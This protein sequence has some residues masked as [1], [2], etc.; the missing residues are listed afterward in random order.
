MR[1]VAHLSDLHFGRTNP[2]M[3]EQLRAHLIQMSPDLIVVSGDLTQRA[4]ISEFLE[5]RAFLDS[6]PKPQIVVPGNHDIE[7]YNLYGRFVQ[8][9][10][11]YRLYISEDVEPFYSDPE[12]LIVSVNTARSLTFK[13]GR[14]N[15]AQ[16]MRLRE[17]LVSAEP[18]AV[19]ILVAHHPIDLP[20]ML[21]HGLAGGAEMMLRSLADSGIDLILSGHLHLSRFTGPSEKLRI[22]GHTSVLVQAGSAVSNRLR[23][24]LNS[25]NWIEVTGDRITIYQRCWSVETSDFTDGRTER[26]V[27][28]TT[29][30]AR[31][32]ES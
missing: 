17:L 10:Q 25:F 16:V 12:L 23:G 27:R 21:N 1:S 29:G 4:R 2:E 18:G 28:S 32:I 9:L 5:A 14:V 15:P 13:G 26:Y 30:W 8:R 24:E 19:K 7:L 22:G 6:L 20:E 11:R 3:V 31:A